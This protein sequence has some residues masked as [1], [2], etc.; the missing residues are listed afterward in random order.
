MRKVMIVLGVMVM[1]VTA[2]WATDPPTKAH[3]LG[4]ANITTHWAT[5]TKLV[6]DYD[7]VVRLNTTDPGVQ[8]DNPNAA[9]ADWS[10][11]FSA[12]TSGE[13]TVMSVSELM[14][15]TLAVGC[16][17]PQCP[18]SAS[19]W[20]DHSCTLMTIKGPKTNKCSQMFEGP[21]VAPCGYGCCGVRVTGW[22]PP[23]YACTCGGTTGPIPTMSCNACGT[24]IQHSK[25]LEFYTAAIAERVK[26]G[27]LQINVNALNFSDG[28]TGDDV[29]SGGIPQ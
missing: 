26:N 2:G 13:Q 14:P 12:K 21:A 27:S 22:P 18:T 25:D 15:G 29:G 16:Q 9:G 19:G 28:T 23:D 10:V 17:P 5:P 8:S 6:V 7:L 24:Q 4:V 20:C 1:M 11:V 3:E